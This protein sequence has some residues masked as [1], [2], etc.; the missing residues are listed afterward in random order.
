MLSNLKTK[1]FLNFHKEGLHINSVVI[2]RFEGEPAAKRFKTK[3]KNM[4]ETVYLGKEIPG[5]PRAIN[6]VVS[7]KGYG[8]Q[9]HIK[10][11]RFNNFLV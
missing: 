5:Y 10:T 9:P 11:K 3:L 7:D 2:T 6:K 4:G 1:L 8:I